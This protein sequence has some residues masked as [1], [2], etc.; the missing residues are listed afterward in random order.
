MGGGALPAGGDT[1]FQ[2]L[3]HPVQPGAEGRQVAAEA[4]VTQPQQAQLHIRPGLE[5]VRQ[6]GTGPLQR[7]RQIQQPLHGD[8]FGETRQCLGIIQPGEQGAAPLRRGFENGHLPCQIAELPQQ[9]RDVLAAAVQLIQQQQGIRRPAVQN[10][11]HHLLGL[12]A[13]GKAQHVQHGTAGELALRHTALIQ[14]AQGIP[15]GAP[16]HAGEDLR[17]VGGEVDLLGLSDV[18][19]LALHVTGQDALEGEA[20]APGEDGGRDLVQLRGGQNEH[21]MLR[22]LLQDLQ[23]SVEGRGGEHMHLVDD[24]H[25]L[26]Q[27]GRGI[28]RLLPQRTDL[29]H[30]VVAGGVQLRDIQRGAGIHGPAGLAP[31]AGLAVHRG[32]AVHRLGQYPGT[33]GLAGT[34]CAGE[35]IGVGGMALGHLTAE[36]IRDVLLSHDLGKHLGPPLAVQRLIH[37]SPPPEKNKNSPPLTAVEPAPSRHMDGPS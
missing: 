25:P 32:Q 33:G 11:A 6:G 37:G 1:L 36:G 14:Q 31:A 3:L 22:R 2:Q 35:E 20:L 10:T 24:I 30:A 12:D 8:V 4:L 21:Q 7:L 5:A 9:G 13:A 27:H 17:S 34:P 28:H 23:Q 18:Q 19:Q 26:F 16:R 29:I 15:Q